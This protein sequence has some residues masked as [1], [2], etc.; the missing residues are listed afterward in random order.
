MVTACSIPHVRETAGVPCL[1]RVP[2]V[3]MPDTMAVKHK[4]NE[5][6][7]CFANQLVLLT[8]ISIQENRIQVVAQM[9][10][11]ARHNPLAQDVRF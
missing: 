5:L 10:L 3:V 6:R 8:S 11:Q 9:I 4:R 2:A 7:I 1:Y